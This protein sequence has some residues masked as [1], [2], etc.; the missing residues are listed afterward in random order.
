SRAALRDHLKRNGI[1]AQALRAH[2]QF[3]LHRVKYGL[4]S[5][6]PLVSVIIPAR[7]Q[8]EMLR[9]C[10]DSVLFG[11]DYP[12]IELIIVDNRGRE[13]ATK[14]YLRS[15]KSDSRVKIINYDHEFNY[16]AINNFAVQ[17]SSGQF[18]CFLNNDVYCLQAD[19]LDEMVRHASRPDIGAVGAR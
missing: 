12:S 13:L 8:S 10:V 9:R 4:P 5:P 11:T 1:D 7:D 3:S 14:D 6:P 19:W 18:L 15:L 17:K 2:P 16:S